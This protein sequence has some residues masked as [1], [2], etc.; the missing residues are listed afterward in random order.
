MELKRAPDL[1]IFCVKIEQI[2][3]ESKSD[4][5]KKCLICTFSNASGRFLSISDEIGGDYEVIV[6]D[7]T[8]GLFFLL[9]RRIHPSV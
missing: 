7:Y 1:V 2:C 6:A 5:K 4:L 8:A 9:E 3:V